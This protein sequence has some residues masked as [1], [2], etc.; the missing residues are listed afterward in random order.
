M[1]VLN[2]L[3]LFVGE[4]YFYMNENVANIYV[5]NQKLDLSYSFYVIEKEDD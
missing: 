2:A 1:W 5:L 3:E 4:K